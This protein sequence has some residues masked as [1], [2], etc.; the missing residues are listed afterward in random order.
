LFLS[1][2][3]AFLPL[4]AGDPRYT[5][6][7]WAAI[8]SIYQK[9]LRHP[10]LTGL[11]DGTLPRERFTFYLQ[12]DARYLTAFAQALNVLSS[13]APREDWMVTLNRH[14]TDAIQAEKS[15]HDSLLKGV[16]RAEQMAPTNYAYTNHL[17]AAVERRTF[18]EGLCAMLPCYW[19]YWEVGKELK[20]RGS[21]N[22]DYQRW[23]DQYSDPS[24]NATV[25]QVLAMANSEADR[26]SVVTRQSGIQ[27]F[28]VSSR[29][30]YQFWDMAWRQ[31]QWTPA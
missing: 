9:T 19:I 7:L 24:Y 17:L 15:L 5:D 14:A 12:Q 11:A 2:P 27:L 6:E 16:P 4:R 21:K 10:F 23:I 1:L 20:K 13:K 3:A 31:E 25:Q 26:A 28:V 18:L 29:Y 30:E 8:E 22:A